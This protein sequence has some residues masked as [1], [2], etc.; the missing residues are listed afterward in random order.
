MP[1]VKT[2]SE[3]FNKSETTNDNESQ[4]N[5]TTITNQEVT[6][7]ME[8]LTTLNNG[9]NGNNDEVK[10]NFTQDTQNE[11]TTSLNLLSDSTGI[12]S[13]LLVERILQDALLSTDSSFYLI[14]LF[15][16]ILKE[17]KVKQSQTQLRQIE[18]EK[19]QKL[20]EYKRLEVE[21]LAYSLR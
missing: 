6:E 15:R 1:R 4:S 11:L 10:I 8:N 18:F 13:G 14:N 3:R 17:A 2:F 20:L 21:A 19:T 12:K 7:I 9:N 16:N 5:L